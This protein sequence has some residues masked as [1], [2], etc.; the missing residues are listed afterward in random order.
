MTAAC[1]PTLTFLRT[2]NEVQTVVARTVEAMPQTAGLL[3]N[4][5]GFG[6]RKKNLDR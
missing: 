1:L 3:T 5:E 4:R 6:Q 2:Q